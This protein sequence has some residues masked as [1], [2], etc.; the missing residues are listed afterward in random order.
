MS[1]FICIVINIY[2]EV[3]IFRFHFEKKIGNIFHVTKSAAWEAEGRAFRVCTKLMG[4]CLGSG[5]S[6]IPC[7]HQTYG[8]LLM[9]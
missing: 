7:M 4:C 3:Y 2:F 1:A 8:L 5:G 9:S 6:R